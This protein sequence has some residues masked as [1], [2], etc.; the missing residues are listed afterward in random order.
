MYYNDMYIHNFNLSHNLKQR[1]LFV[2]L[3]IL[4]KETAFQ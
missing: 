3:T 2:L 1:L 4:D